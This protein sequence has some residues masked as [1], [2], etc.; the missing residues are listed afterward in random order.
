MGNHGKRHL[1]RPVLNHA[2]AVHHVSVA[3]SGKSLKIQEQFLSH[4]VCHAVG[5]Y[6]CEVSNKVHQGH[7][8]HKGG[9]CEHPSES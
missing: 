7:N 4:F 9:V 2:L 8:G 3:K 5:T 6:L 1:F